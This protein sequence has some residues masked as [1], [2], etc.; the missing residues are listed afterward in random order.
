M[1]PEKM[2]EKAYSFDGKVWVEQGPQIVE[3]DC[4]DE[5]LSNDV[6]H[7]NYGIGKR[8]AHGCFIR[9]DEMPQSYEKDVVALTVLRE[10]N[11][12]VYGAVEKGQKMHCVD[13]HAKHAPHLWKIYQSQTFEELNS[14][15]DIVKSE[16]LVK[17]KEVEGKDEALAI[18]ESIA[19]SD[20][21]LSEIN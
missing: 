13:W 10:K 5:N 2:N 6:T 20:E 12:G 9:P 3:L 18:G 21:I 7:A 14:H 4:T 1:T 11:L 15:G 16:R 17:V 8:D 19:A